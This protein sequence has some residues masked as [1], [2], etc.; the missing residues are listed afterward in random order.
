VKRIEKTAFISYRRADI[1]W[2]LLIYEKLKNKGYDAFFDFKAIGSGAFERITLENVC[3]RAHFLLLL[4]PGALDR[5]SRKGDWLLK[6]IVAAIR[7]KRNV[8]PLFIDNFSFDKLTADSM[9]PKTL[10][11]LSRYNGLDV[12]ARYLDASIERL[13]QQFLNIPLEWVDHPASAEA[14]TSAK[15]QKDAA[16]GF[17]GGIETIRSIGETAP[18]STE[19]LSIPDRSLLHGLTGQLDRLSNPPIQQHSAESD[20]APTADGSLTYGLPTTEAENLREHVEM[21][22]KLLKRSPSSSHYVSRASSYWYLHLYE[23]ALQ[24]LNAALKL[25][26]DMM[27][28]RLTRGQVLAEMGRP[29]EAMD[30]LDWAI[31]KCVERVGYLYRARALAHAQLGDRARANADITMAIELEPENAW[32]FFTRAQ[33][34]EMQGDYLRARADYQTALGKRRPLLNSAKVDVAVNRCIGDSENLHEQIGKL[35]NLIE[36]SPSSTLYCQRATLYWYMHLCSKALVDLEVA[37]RLEPDMPQARFTRGQVLA[38]MERPIEALQD[39]DWAMRA[40][41]QHVGYLYRARAQAYA[42]LGSWAEAEIV[43]TRAIELEPENAWAFF[44]R[45]Q[46]RDMQGDPRR[47]REDYE[48]ALRKRGPKLNDARVDVA[49]TRLKQL[50]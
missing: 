42:Q 34:W 5:C 23:K 44:T 13:D 45:A 32:A 43:I 36:I 8:I 28:A 22:S 31:D 37:L 33:M 35:T 19:L 38:D 29:R 40:R 16:D 47:A 24:D 26:P 48:L 3:A 46:I 27:R 30:D 17:L 21:L 10:L 4:T 25:E 41:V 9:V 18:A 50:Q 2:A 14:E 7:S 1:A 11:T 12:S 15:R 49:I 20:S 6:E 39:L